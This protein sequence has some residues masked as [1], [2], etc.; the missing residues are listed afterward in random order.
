MGGACCSA[1]SHPELAGKNGGKTQNPATTSV[2]LKTQNPA[3]TPVLLVGRR[4][5]CVHARACR[6]PHKH[7]TGWGRPPSNLNF[8]S[9]PPGLT[10]CCYKALDVLTDFGEAVTVTGVKTDSNKEFQVLCS[11]DSSKWTV[12]ASH[13][14]SSREFSMTSTA[15]YWRMSWKETRGHHGFHCQFLGNDTKAQRDLRR[16]TQPGGRGP[17]ENVKLGSTIEKDNVFLLGNMRAL[18]QA[19]L[20]RHHHKTGWGKHPKA[21]SFVTIDGDCQ[22]SGLTGCCYRILDVETDYGREVKITGVKTDFATKPFSVLVSQNG[23]KWVKIANIMSKPISSWA[24]SPI[25]A[26]FSRLVW[27]NTN[28]S[29]GFHCQLFGLDTP[30]QK[31]KRAKHKQLLSGPLSGVPLRPGLLSGI[32]PLIGKMQ[33]LAAGCRCNHPHLTGWGKAPEELSF[34]LEGMGESEGNV[35]GGLTGCCFKQLDIRTDYGKDVTIRGVRVYGSPSGFEILVSSDGSKWLQIAQKLR[36]TSSWNPSTPVRARFSRLVWQSTRG[37]HGFKCQLYGDDTEDQKRRRKGVDW[38]DIEV[39]IRNVCQR[40]ASSAAPLAVGS[41]AMEQN[42][43][44]GFI[45]Q[46][47]RQ[48]SEEMRAHWAKERDEKSVHPSYV[49]ATSMICLRAEWVSHTKTVA[50]LDYL[51]R[52]FE[53]DPDLRKAL[54]NRSFFVNSCQKLIMRGFRL[55]DEKQASRQKCLMTGANLLEQLKGMFLW[56]RWRKVYFALA[57]K[58]WALF[59]TPDSIVAKL[60][61]FTD[62]S[63]R[64]ASAKR[65]AFDMVIKHA[66][67][68]IQAHGKAACSEAKLDSQAPLSPKRARQRCREIFEE[69]IDLHKHLAYK[70]AFEEPVRAY[71]NARGDTGQRDHYD[72]HGFNWYL[73]GTMSAIGMQLPLIPYLS[74]TCIM[75]FAAHWDTNKGGSNLM[76][77]EFSKLENFGRRFEGIA[78]VKRLRR[79]DMGVAQQN[80]FHGHCGTPKAF[81][82]SLVKPGVTKRGK[83]WAKYMERLAHFF[84]VDFFCSKAIA[85]LMQENTDNPGLMGFRSVLEV[86]FREYKREK[87][88]A[89]K[90]IQEDTMVEF[91]YDEGTSTYDA[92]RVNN[93]LCFA[94]ITREEVQIKER[95]HE[96]QSS[97]TQRNNLG[98]FKG[99]KRLFNRVEELLAHSQDT[100]AIFRTCKKETLGSNAEIFAAIRAI[101]SRQAIG[102][103]GGEA[104]PT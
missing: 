30:D 19:C 40:T 9:G 20:C 42:A 23:K 3:T 88:K 29:T 58:Y 17:L 67:K 24:S 54:E 97:V 78:A 85:V 90:P 64:C 34:V 10:G 48:K 73:A 7:P 87:A 59:A 27:E 98:E 28:G 52:D 26:R 57:L 100:T 81:A 2:L 44:G 66:Y 103:N 69:Y 33:A 71:Y 92:A 38:S 13:V 68:I 8:D 15:R 79:E 89:G 94:G 96:K 39:R 46:L 93:L 61:E 63:R 43:G 77:E 82:N 80:S 72:V 5:K 12:V 14:N 56:L 32:V 4:M 102:M 45:T 31:Q 49:K 75:G 36:N 60:G 70:S 74:D 50:I 37:S 22:T 65:L 91:V 11:N 62:R 16:E 35:G 104:N 95:K 25:P 86:L 1:A 41:S 101:R 18:R 47:H 6:C 53:G 51:A 83:A 76:W 55:S 21:L 84:T 99:S